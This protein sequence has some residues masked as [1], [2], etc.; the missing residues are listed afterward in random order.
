MTLVDKVK[1]T[2]LDYIRTIDVTRLGSFPEMRD[3]KELDLLRFLYQ[4][5]VI[6]NTSIDAALEEAVFAQARKDY[7]WVSGGHRRYADHVSS[8]ECFAYALR[9]GVFSSDEVSK[10]PFDHGDT[11]ETYPQDYGSDKLFDGLRDALF[12]VP[13]VLYRRPPGMNPV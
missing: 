10:I 4:G 12:A 3:N 1:G 6:D 5:G 9:K 7:R 2:V 13:H 8:P 11:A